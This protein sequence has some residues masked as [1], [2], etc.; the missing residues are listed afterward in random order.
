MLEMSPRTE[1][2]TQTFT[3]FERKITMKIA[4]TLLLVR[5]RTMFVP[6]FF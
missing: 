3:E 5:I 4:H 6:S 2:E 1:T